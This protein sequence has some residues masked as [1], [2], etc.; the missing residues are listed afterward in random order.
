MKICVIGGAGFIGSR[1]C[2]QLLNGGHEVV[3][4][5]K[6][7][8]D[9]SADCRCSYIVGDVRNI[10]DIERAVV[11]CD[12][13]YN[14]AAEHQDNVTPL[15]LYDDVNVGG[16]SNICEVAAKFNIERIIF[17]SSV[18]VYGSHSAP[19]SELTHHAYFNDYGRTKH[20][21]EE[22]FEGWLVGNADRKLTIVRP[23]VVFGPGNR[24]NVYNFLKQIKRG[25]FV[26]IG[27]G[28]NIKSMAYVENVVSFLVYLAARPKR[29]EIF[30]YS[31]KPDLSVRELV[32]FSDSVLGRTEL[33]RLSLP[34]WLGVS[35]GI[36]ADVASKLLRRSL[37]ISEIR[38]RK[39][40][41]PSE[42]DASKAMNSGFVPPVQMIKGLEE[43]IRLH[44]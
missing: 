17:T 32:N 44:V 38:V 30:N 21:A 11:G 12:I 9:G 37:P 6:L 24:G 29:H 5:D 8:P 28:N 7:E 39:F 26:M 33:R 34:L 16:A 41:S 27:R 31:D 3:L 13:I 36:A 18:A 19:M 25:P 14:L 10:E 4:M 43:M 1:L 20:L 35:I 42:I 2:K 23:T 40:C 22:V 15:S